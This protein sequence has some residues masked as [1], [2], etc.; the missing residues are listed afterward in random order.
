MNFVSTSPRTDRRCSRARG[1]SLVELLVAMSVAMAFMAGVYATYFQIVRTQEATERRMEALAN[2]RAAIDTMSTE[3]KAIN[4][5]PGPGADNVL[6]F[7]LDEVST[8]GDRID[9]DGDGQ[10]D[11]EIVDGRN[12]TATSGTTIAAGD[13]RHAAIG[14]YYDRPHGVGAYDLGDDNV[15]QDIRFG[16]D[17]LSFDIYPDPPAE[18]V[19]SKNITYL[20]T[21]FEG[22]PDVLVRQA[23]IRRTDGEPQVTVAPLAFDVLGLDVLYWDPNEPPSGQAWVT[24][25]NSELSNPGHPDSSSPS[26]LQPPLGLPAAVYVRLTLLADPN[27]RERMARGEPVETLNIETTIAIEQTIGDARFPRTRL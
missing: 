13:D 26:T 15:D 6:F 5:N 9:N 14:A 25:W 24:R 27:G 10:I 22:Q 18:G 11:E 23:T 1:F 17:T 8:L 12:D 19:A 16:R 20:V 2:A 4:R 21:T 3:I 7:G